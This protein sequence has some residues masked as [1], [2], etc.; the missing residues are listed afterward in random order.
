MGERLQNKV[1]NFSLPEGLWD[2]IR[3]VVLIR[4]QYIVTTDE[5]IWAIRLDWDDNI[6]IQKV[7][8]V[9]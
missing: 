5:G 2:T 8:Y 6:T 3:S 7:N 1:F 9:P 4:D